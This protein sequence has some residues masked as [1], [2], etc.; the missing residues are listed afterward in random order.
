MNY[1]NKYNIFL[2]LNNADNLTFNSVSL[3]MLFNSF[4]HYIFAFKET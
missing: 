2:N 4:S 1:L 3:Y